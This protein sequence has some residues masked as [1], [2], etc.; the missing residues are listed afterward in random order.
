MRILLD[1]GVPVQLRRV[2]LPHLWLTARSRG[3]DR[4][5]NGDLLRAAESELFDVLVTT[6]QNLVYQQ[7]NSTRRIALVV[8]GT[9]SL[10]RL[11]GVADVIKDAVSRACPGSYE[12]IAVPRPSS[13]R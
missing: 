11:L 6:D 10:Q 5:A 7:N 9:N 2:F 1:H 8:L 4:L 3:W 13:S 12:F